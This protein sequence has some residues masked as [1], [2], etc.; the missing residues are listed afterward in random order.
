MNSIIFVSATTLK[1]NKKQTTMKKTTL[2]FFL[3][4]S[5]GYAQT[6]TRSFPI[7]ASSVG[8]SMGSSA[9]IVQ[10]TDGGYLLNYSY[11]YP[12][13]D[14]GAG[15]GTTVIKTD[16]N[17]VPQWSRKLYGGNG[18]KTFVLGD[19]SVLLFSGLGNLLKLDA[20]GQTVMSKGN[21][22]TYPIQLVISDAELVGT[23]I[24]AVGSVDTYNGFGWVTSSIAVM[25]DFD[26]D[27]N[28]L[29]TQV[30]GSLKR[31]SNILH[32]ALGNCY[33]AGYLGN[34][35]SYIYKIGAN[36]TVLWAK[37]FQSPIANSSTSINDLKILANGD[38]ILA[39]YFYNYETSLGSMLLCRLSPDGSLI[40][41][42][43]NGVYVS[44]FDSIT[45]L[46]DG[47]LVA[48]GF[49]R[50]TDLSFS[51]TFAM[52]MDSSGAISWSKL[53]N[54][55]FAISAPLVKETNNWY[56]T[57]FHNNYTDNNN[58]IVFNTENTG[59]TDCPYRSIDLTL[60]DIS[61][62]V[63]PIVF[64]M[65]TDAS[66]L[67]PPSDGFEYPTQTQTYA[68]ACLVPLSVKEVN[69]KEAKVWPN[70]ST[71][72][73]HFASDEKIESITVW[74]VAGQQISV[75]RPNQLETS[76][77]I[78]NNGLYLVKIETEHGTTTKKIVISR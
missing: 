43:A 56:Y 21:F 8:Y 46:P 34:Q 78:D 26:L 23:T 42:K 75:H 14:A 33:V 29:Q 31:P 65:T 19:G 68:D 48:T 30:L 49:L 2:L 62:N 15:Y 59:V 55:G 18:K 36:N 32:D 10:T 74:N 38:V 67:A 71:G 16:A 69:L 61:L 11:S 1:T 13:W 25:V 35:G 7:T 47:G 9:P 12:N 45:V 54:E 17:F 28:L 53:Y 5:L 77:T 39:G 44:S 4:T 51:R 70:P 73:I 27:G 20:N 6:I 60:S 50:E 37:R 40:S 22:T 63:T 57:A 58:P 64:T 52:R 3:L 24:K 66:L 76:I 41:A 72:T